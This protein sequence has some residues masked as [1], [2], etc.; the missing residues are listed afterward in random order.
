MTDN[1]EALRN[2]LKDLR[3]IFTE[4]AQRAPTTRATACLRTMRFAAI[5]PDQT[6]ASAQHFFPMSRAQFS[7]DYNPWAAGQTPKYFKK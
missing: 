2:I 5:L 6:S 7:R 1:L 4:L 3:D